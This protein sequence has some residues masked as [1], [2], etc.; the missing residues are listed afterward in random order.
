M[1]DPKQIDLTID[2]LGARGDGISDWQG[3]PIYVDGA[4]PDETIR[5]RLAQGRGDGKAA[6]L[7][8]ILKASPDRREPPC[9]HARECGGCTL[10]HAKDVA[11][12]AWKLDLLTVPLA[13]S[14]LT[15]LAIEPLLVAPP[16]SRRRTRLGIKRQGK[17][18]I[19]GFRGRRS[20]R[21]VAVEGCLVLTPALM[22]ARAGL[23]PLIADLDVNE[24]ELTETQTGIDLVLH[25]ENLPDLSG[26]ERITAVAQDLDL[27]RVS[28]RDNRSTTPL[29]ARHTPEVSF[30]GISV[31]L[32]AGG[33][34]Q[35]TLWGEKL[36]ADRVAE[37]V[38]SSDHIA[39]LYAGIGT[40]GFRLH[41]D[42]AIT[43]V[44]GQPEMAAAMVDAARRAGLT[45]GFCAHQR[46][47]ARSPL[48]AVELDRFDAVIFDPPRQ[49]AREQSVQ[50]AASAVPVVVAVSCHPQS[51]SRDARILIDGGYRLD[52]I[53]PID[54][55]LWSH[56]LELVAVFR[57]G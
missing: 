55:F 28:W 22:A 27:A 39:D 8:D 50:I 42:H 38:G 25:G 7:E 46:D 44:E 31:A 10:Q 36:M 30:G 1:P 48:T 14:G 6:V 41:H 51:F 33:F 20:R 26:L 16:A 23:V 37:A 18:A 24:I 11:Y 4:L 43:A 21:V 52:T 56:H 49:G 12:R 5:V 32:P 45:K 17:H 34:L 40:F 15:G 13:R 2:R 47:L 19:V 3:S 29:A 35:P 53:W 9:S 54:Q 57:R